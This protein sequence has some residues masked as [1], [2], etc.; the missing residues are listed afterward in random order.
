M[1][2]MPS[3]VIDLMKKEGTV[4]VLVTCSKM[5]VPHA[6]AA[7]AIMSPSP[8]KLVFGEVLSK[9]STKNLAENDKAAFL[10]VNGMESYEI[11]CKVKAKLTSGSELESM[12]K[13]LE[14]FHLRANALWVFDVQS[15]YEQGANPNAGKKIA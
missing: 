7:G 4:K 9:V 8:D 5:G 1:T 2:V 13:A 15:V 3:K 12:N 14:A 10:I 11:S 6:I